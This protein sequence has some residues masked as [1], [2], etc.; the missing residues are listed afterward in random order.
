MFFCLFFSKLDN[1]YYLHHCFIRNSPHSS[2]QMAVVHKISWLAIVVCYTLLFK[3][4]ARS[5]MHC[6]WT[7]YRLTTLWSGMSG[8]IFL[9]NSRSRHIDSDISRR[10]WLIYARAATLAIS[11][12]KNTPHWMHKCRFAHLC[13]HAF[14][15]NDTSIFINVF[16]AFRDRFSSRFAESNV[17]F[18]PL[19]IPESPRFLGIL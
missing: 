8:A 14:F 12:S 16:F 18:S 3:Q 7:S 6:G 19:S 4:F 11:S 13:W 2:E 9:C 5:K 10:Y 1:L 15:H 17:V